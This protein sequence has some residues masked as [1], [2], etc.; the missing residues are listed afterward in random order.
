MP[1][2]FRKTWRDREEKAG[3]R[4]AP[5]PKQ[6]KEESEGN[7]TMTQAEFLYGKNRKESK[8]PPMS[9]KWVEK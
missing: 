1:D 7:G 9:K 8:R 3:L 2:I 5:P 6:E 4:E